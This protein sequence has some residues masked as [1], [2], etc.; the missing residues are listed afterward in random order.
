MSFGSKG[1]PMTIRWMF[2]VI[3]H[4]E[5]IRAIFLGSVYIIVYVNTPLHG[6]FGIS[7]AQRRRPMLCRRLSEKARPIGAGVGA[8][9]TDAMAAVDRCAKRKQ[10]EV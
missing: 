9:V 3:I 10:H 4:I 7:F 5:A 1:C 6:A 2:L 8:R